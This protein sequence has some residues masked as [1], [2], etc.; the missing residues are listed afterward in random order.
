MKLFFSRPF[1][2]DYTEVNLHICSEN[3]LT[4]CGIVVLI[5]CFLNMFIFKYLI[6]RIIFID[7]I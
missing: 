4:V 3:L 7:V 6:N 5:L 2:P 1:A